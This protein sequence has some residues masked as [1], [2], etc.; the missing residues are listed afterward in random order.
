MHSWQHLGDRV[1]VATRGPRARCHLCGRVIS[2][3]HRY[4][5]R[6]G[7]YDGRRLTFRMHLPC[8][9]LSQGWSQ[10]DWDHFKHAQFWALTEAANVESR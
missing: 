1:L 7:V 4:V 9:R 6:R 3:G 10:D 8:E 2:R 5:V